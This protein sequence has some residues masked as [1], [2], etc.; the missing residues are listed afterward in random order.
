MIDEVNC[1]ERIVNALAM[2]M[3]KRE[4]QIKSY[5]SRKYIQ[6]LIDNRTMFV[7]SG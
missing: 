6:S 2:C 1:Q 7:P 4:K 3:P 5:K